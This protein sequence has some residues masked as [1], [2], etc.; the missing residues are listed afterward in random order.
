MIRLFLKS[1]PV[2]RYRMLI[3]VHGTKYLNNYENK[4]VLRFID[5]QTYTQNQKVENVEKEV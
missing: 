1:I 3:K 5:N 4:V 2:F